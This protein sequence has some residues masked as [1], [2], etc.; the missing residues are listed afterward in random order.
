MNVLNRICA[1]K[2]EHIRSMKAQTPL[3]ALE[4]KIKNTLPAKG[5]IKQIKKFG[6]AGKT[7]LIAE[8]KKASPSRG[9]IRAD[10]DPVTIAQIYEEGGAACLSVLTDTPYF[11]GKDDYLTQIKAVSTLPVLRKD[12]MLDPYQIAES[13]ALGADCILL[14]MAALEDAQ[15]QELYEAATAYKMDVLVEVHEEEELERALS[16]SPAMIGVNSRNLKTLDV[17]IETAA[18]LAA[19][20]PDPILKIGE[21]GIET[22]EDV[23]YLKSKGYQGFLVGE[24]LMRQDDIGAAVKKLLS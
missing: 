22:K 1:D 18:R 13:R 3:S 6:L 8:V 9:V 16:L 10:F 2:W 14:I 7:A 5:F 12:F 11:Q 20:I 23:L 24:S 4:E 17:D 19:S 21:S 15:A